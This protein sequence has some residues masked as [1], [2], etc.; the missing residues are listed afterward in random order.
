MSEHDPI[1]F[2]TGLGARL[3]TRSR[4]VCVFLGAGTSKACGLPDLAQLQEKVL[5]SVSS[6]DKDA[7]HPI[8]KSRNLEQALTRLRRI[9][10]LLSGDEKIDGLTGK[11]AA[12]LDLAVCRAIIK[13]LDISGSNIAPA[14]CFAAWAA[15]ANYHAPL[16]IFTVNYDLLIE[17]GLERR[18]IPYFDGFVGNLRAP[19]QTEMVEAQN[20]DGSC[21]PPIF[22]RLWKL[23]GSVNWIRE[24]NGQIVRLGC[25][26]DGGGA[27]AIYPSD[28]KYEESRRVPFVVLQ[29]RFR[30]ALLA[31]ETLLLIAGYSFNDDHLNEMLFDAAKNRERS[32]LVAF[33]YSKI[34]EHLAS[35]ALTTPNFQIVGANDAIIGGTRAK[36]KVPSSPQPNVWDKDAFL[37]GD[38]AHLSA[39]L[40]RSSTRDPSCEDDLRKLL[41]HLSS[42]T[43]KAGGG[44][45]G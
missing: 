24:S 19:F 8:L 41:E 14:E 44:I 5:T 42:S 29:D 18:G 26:V 21:V 28:T 17:T 16:E 2:V 30:K 20:G 43:H 22:V 36:W 1:A 10:A 31:P 34:P 7:L 3:A 12:E 39:F 32:E 4:H 23:H 40:A 15:M 25:P 45:S 9:S 33:C 27:V 6:R 38:F 35:R 11:V 13:A 37:L